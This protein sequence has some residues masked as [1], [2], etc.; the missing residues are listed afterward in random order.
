MAT[1]FAGSSSRD[2]ERSARVAGSPLSDRVD[3]RGR[4]RDDR[5]RRVA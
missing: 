2:R 4:A 5:R 3:R 1:R